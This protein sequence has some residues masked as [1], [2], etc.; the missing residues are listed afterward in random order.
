MGYLREFANDRW[1]VVVEDDDQVAYAYLLH[2]GT[3]VSDLWLYNR[4]ENPEGPPWKQ[5][6]ASMPFR[7]SIDYVRDGTAVQNPS[8]DDVKVIW[9]SADG[10][11]PE[12]TICIGDWAIGWL[13]P[14]AKPGWSA[15]VKRSGQIGRAHV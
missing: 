15:L 3:I 14:D 12:V 11:N 7:N 1:T 2:D 9:P 4:G 5:Q 6:G 13:A 10:A 8:A